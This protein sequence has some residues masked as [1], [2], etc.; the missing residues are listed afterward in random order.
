MLNRLQDSILKRVRKAESS[1][2]RD[3]QPTVWAH[4]APRPLDAL[5]TCGIH[6]ASG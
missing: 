4:P 6:N 3:N 1:K 5:A 2:K